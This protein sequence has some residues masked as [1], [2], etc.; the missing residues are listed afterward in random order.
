MKGDN[1]VN[2]EFVF[3]HPLV[4]STFDQPEA[5]Q[6]VVYNC[7]DCACPA[8]TKQNIV[9]RYFLLRSAIWK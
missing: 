7:E 3:R 6:H 8:S 2:Q 4:L 9:D 5:F 1:T